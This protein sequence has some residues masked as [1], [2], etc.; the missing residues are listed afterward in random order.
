MLVYTSTGDQPLGM[1][2]SGILTTVMV[3]SL[4]RLERVFS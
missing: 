3:L 1:I 2:A 4:R